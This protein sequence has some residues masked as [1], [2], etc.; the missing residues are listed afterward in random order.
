MEERLVDPDMQP[1]DPADQQ[2]RPQNLAN[3]V[4]QA[5]LKDNLSVF[6]QAS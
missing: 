2:L 6:I 4:G 3:F 1:T 5:G